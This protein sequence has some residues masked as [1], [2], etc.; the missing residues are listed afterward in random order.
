MSLQGRLEVGRLARCRQPRASRRRSEVFEPRA[1]TLIFGANCQ[2]VTVS[3]RSDQSESPKLNGNLDWETTVS[4]SPSKKK[5]EIPGFNEPRCSIAGSG[6]S[7]VLHLQL[8]THTGGKK[9]AVVHLRRPARRRRYSRSRAP[10][11]TSHSRPVRPTR[12][13]RSLD[14]PPRL[15]QVRPDAR[16]PIDAPKETLREPVGERRSTRAGLRRLAVHTPPAAAVA[17][18]PVQRAEET[19][20]RVP[21]GGRGDGALL[22]RR[23]SRRGGETGSGPITPLDCS[24]FNRQGRV[25]GFGRVREFHGTP[26]LVASLGDDVVVRLGGGLQRRE[27]RGPFERLLIRQPRLVARKCDDSAVRF[28]RAIEQRD[29]VQVPRRRGGTRRR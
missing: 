23:R 14:V 9:I 13:Q 12:V 5:A 19:I 26:R 15:H 7:F 6:R 1:P 17:S 18:S 16:V 8:V 29:P 25:R 22:V 24:A 21:P 11:P 2:S 27:R 3:K 4:R 10:G 20:E 28:R